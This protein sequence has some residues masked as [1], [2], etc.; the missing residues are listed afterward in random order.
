[1][2]RKNV[3]FILSAVVF[4]LTV[5]LTILTY[6]NVSSVFGTDVNEPT[7]EQIANAEHAVLWKQNTFYDEEIGKYIQIARVDDTEEYIAFVM[8]VNEDIIDYSAGSYYPVCYWKGDY[9]EG[10]LSEKEFL[11]NEYRAKTADETTVYIKDISSIEDEMSYYS[12]G[13][14]SRGYR[15]GISIKERYEKCSCVRVYDISAYIGSVQSEAHKGILKKVGQMVGLVLAAG[16]CVVGGGVSLLLL[17][18]G[19][20]TRKKMSKNH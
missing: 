12:F 16:I 17:I 14:K 6:I 18:F 11:S 1:M 4:T 7:S 9:H 19:I 3:F 2:K 13:E 20:Y 8:D 15:K 5:A 10:N